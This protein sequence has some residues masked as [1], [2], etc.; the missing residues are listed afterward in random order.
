MDPG[1]CSSLIALRHYPLVMLRRR[2]VV[3]LLVSGLLLAGCSDT[4]GGGNG[5]DGGGGEANVVTG[6]AEEGIEGVMAVR[7]PE[8][9][10]TEGIVDYGL[11]PPAG[12]AHNPVWL[13][14][15][16]YDQPTPD[17]N[18]VHDLEHGAVWLAYSPDLPAADLEVIHEMA[19]TNP[20][21]VATPYP[22]LAGGAAVVATAW[23]RQLTLDSVDDPRLEAFAAQYVDGSQ[24]PEAGVTCSSS[25]LGTPIP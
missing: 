19:R 9:T 10:H 1:G 21:I 11:R 22:D 24:A 15:G 16:F 20:K 2:P 13:N 6:P 7:V 25:P 12:G 18:L 8:N 14:C 17:E 4:D 5:G 3:T 23:A